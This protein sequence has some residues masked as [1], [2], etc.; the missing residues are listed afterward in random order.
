MWSG[1][2][3]FLFL[4]KS[5]LRFAT[6][7]S[8]EE[9]FQYFLDDYAHRVLQFKKIG[10]LH[11]A[12]V[13]G[14]QTWRGRRSTVAIGF[15]IHLLPWYRIR[16]AHAHCVAV[17]LRIRAFRPV[18]A[19]WKR[20]CQSGCWPQRRFAQSFWWKFAWWGCSAYLTLGCEVIFREKCTQSIMSLFIFRRFWP[21]ISSDNFYLLFGSSSLTVIPPFWQHP[22]CSAYLPIMWVFLKR[23]DQEVLR[24][25]VWGRCHGKLLSV[26]RRTLN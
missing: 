1:K 26:K 23:C 16:N 5:S 18:V 2:F 21:P 11:L 24:E 17:E 3:H 10:K 22:Q 6:T 20:R 19:L 14:R 25:S 9:F 8:E 7:V 15:L 13:D 4:R 12:Q